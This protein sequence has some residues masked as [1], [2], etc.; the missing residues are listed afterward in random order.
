[1]LTKGLPLYKK[2]AD[3]T[4]NFADVH[5]HIYTFTNLH[6][7]S[8]PRFKKIYIEIT[9]RCNLN[10]SFCIGQQRPGRDMTPEEFELITKRI[11]PY[12]E[13]IYLHVYGEPLLHPDLREILDLAGKAELKIN[14]TTNGV[15]LNL[16]EN[17]PYLQ[18]AIRQINIS[19]HSKGGYEN[20]TGQK[21]YAERML[22]FA[23]HASMH[24]HT[25][26]SLRLWNLGGGSSNDHLFNE[27]VL[28]RLQERF[29]FQAPNMHSNPRK[30]GIKIRDSLYLNFDQRFQWPVN[31]NTQTPVPGFCRGLKDQIAVLSD[32]TIVPCCLDAAG[33]IN[34]GN[35]FTDHLDTIL[36]KARTRQMMDGFKKRMALEPLCIGCSYKDRF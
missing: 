16:D 26:I 33:M 36:Q 15:L 34:L 3:K 11:K 1:M 17:H 10:C 9:N 23:D 27:M 35:I 19:L 5:L 28:E 12:T 2:T 7:T 21:E 4:N 8:M 29:Q 13:Y 32:G 25:I 6:I 22:L 14:L 24:S 20:S 30:R 18:P 31:T